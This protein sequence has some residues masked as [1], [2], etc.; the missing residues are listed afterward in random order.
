M[1]D[2]VGHELDVNSDTMPDFVHEAC[3]MHFMDA[4]IAHLK[5][6]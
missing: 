6:D 1:L 5:A 3:S 2:M 4:L